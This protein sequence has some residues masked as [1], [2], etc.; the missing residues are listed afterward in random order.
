MKLYY[1]T[2]SHALA[3][4]TKY[5]LIWSLQ[6]QRWESGV[7]LRKKVI[8]DKIRWQKLGTNF[9]QLRNFSCSE[10]ERKNTIFLRRNFFIHEEVVK[11][12]W[13]V[14]A[15]NDKNYPGQLFSWKSI[16]KLVKINSWKDF[17]AENKFFSNKKYRK[18]HVN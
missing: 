1:L 13:H 11:L 10:L 14:L 17:F 2:Y 8:S 7:I 4:F 12:H 15:A 3:R 5:D 16:S 6:L 18:N 9:G